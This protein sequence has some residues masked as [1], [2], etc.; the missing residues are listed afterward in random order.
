M[1]QRSETIKLPR[2]KGFRLKAEV[3]PDKLIKVVIPAK[4]GIQGFLNSLNSW[5][6]VYTGMT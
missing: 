5:I 2:E 1:D 4:A 3:K 6:P